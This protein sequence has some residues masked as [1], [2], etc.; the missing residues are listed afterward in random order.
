MDASRYQAWE[1]VLRV[2]YYLDIPSPQYMW[3]MEESVRSVRKIMP[4]TQIIH[5]TTTQFPKDIKLGTTDIRRLD[6]PMDCFYGYRKCKAQASI[7]GECLFMDVDCIVKKDVSHIFNASFDVALCVRYRTK[8][9]EKTPYN[10]GVAFSRC[11]RFWDDVA[12]KPEYH[13]SPVDTERRLSEIAL[14]P[15]Y[16]VRAVNGHVYNYSPFQEVEDLSEKAIVHYKGNRKDYLYKVT[17]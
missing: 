14:D 8:M 12:G 10:G 16:N 9:I 13:V 17:P 1:R 3:F 4:G 15:Q 2:A 6:L 11:S 5:L 7:E